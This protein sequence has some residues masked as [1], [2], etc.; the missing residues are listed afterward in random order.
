MGLS[1][2]LLGKSDFVPPI[3]RETTPQPSQRKRSNTDKTDQVTLPV[4]KKEPADF[5]KTSKIKD[6]S[7][8][9]F[10][11]N[12]YI[13]ALGEFHRGN[14]SSARKLLEEL[15]SDAKAEGIEI[16]VEKSLE[17]M[18]E[19]AKKNPYIDLPVSRKA[20]MSKMSPTLEAKRKS[21]Q[22]R[23]NELLRPQ[24][25]AT[26]MVGANTSVDAKKHSVIDLQQKTDEVIFD[27]AIALPTEALRHKV[28][29]FRINYSNVKYSGACPDITIK[30][31]LPLSAV[32]KADLRM[33]ALTAIVSKYNLSNL[34]FKDHTVISL[35][36]N[37]ADQVDSLKISKYEK[38]QLLESIAFDVAVALV[39][40]ADTDDQY[41]LHFASIPLAREY[42]NFG[43]QGTLLNSFFASIQLKNSSTGSMSTD[44]FVKQGGA[45]CRGTNCI[46][47]A[48]LNTGYS[49]IGSDREARVL[50]VKVREGNN[51]NLFN[52]KTPEDH[53]IVLVQDKS[54]GEHRVMD[55]FWARYNDKS[56]RDLINGK[57]SDGLLVQIVGANP[58]PLQQFRNMSE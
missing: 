28:G 10:A 46:Y 54:S 19:Y 21:V 12:K 49:R 58:Y 3:G 52:T 48:L 4:L 44:L 32:H 15:A 55:S 37:I 30:F 40:T 50:Y 13:K 56:L 6:V 29:E 27:N 7:R 8:V 34:D 25:A 16:D 41:L 38:E 22:E 14:A 2:D 33:Q 26:N 31:T 42:F 45:D 9:K 5:G 17:V 53:N 35:F 20:K 11:N 47:A 24:G 57:I 36:D 43:Q 39:G 1:D 23:Q 51:V 18:A